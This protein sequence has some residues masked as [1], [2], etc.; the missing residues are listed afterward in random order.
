VAGWRDRTVP[1]FLFPVTHPFLY[2]RAASLDDA[3]LALAD[4]G[5]LPLGGGTDL[6]VTIAEEIARPDVLVDLRSIP[7]SE[8]IVALEDGRVRIGATARIGDIARNEL[9]RE[10]YS[11]LAQACDVVGSPA[12]RH[13]GTIGGNLCQ[14]PRC[15]YFRQGI[16]CLKNGGGGCPAVEGE[17]QYLAI[18][19]G[20]PCYIVHPSDPAVALTALDADVEIASA[21]GV[22]SV[23]IGEFY[24]LPR[25]RVDQETILAS[26]EVVS[27]V[28]LPRESAGGVQR[29]HKLMQREA[30]DFA[31]VSVAGAKRPD[32]DVR[33]V[34]GGVAPRPWRVN[35]SVEED[36]SSGGLDDDTIATLADRALL[37]VEPLSK[38]AYK[39]DLTAAMLRRVIA[40]LA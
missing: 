37:D 20:G 11:A 32:G 2:R 6:L 39:V 27:A 10:R 5:A 16:S 24:T 34:C 4:P 29:Y 23:P 9:I 30:W 25:D 38:N 14:R 3:T 22:R 31:L 18:V 33:I 26:G 40:E 12:L 17:N 1:P 7:N 28:V 36:V 13:M 8:A 15:W 19:D 35:S 21:T